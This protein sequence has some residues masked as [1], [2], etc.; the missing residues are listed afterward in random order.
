MRKSVFLAMI[1]MILGVAGAE[2]CFADDPAAGYW[3]SID[4]K[5]GRATA[6]WELY[7]VNGEL[8]GRILSLAGYPEDVKAIKCKHPTQVFRRRAG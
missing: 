8:R 4:D 3:I 5:T 6:G 7:V 2:V 1:L